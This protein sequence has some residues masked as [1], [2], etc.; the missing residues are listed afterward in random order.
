MAKRDY[1]E[2]LGVSKEASTDEIK[3]A[4]RRL[5]R[6]YHPDV[7]KETGAEDK[8]KEINEAYGILGDEKKRSQYDRFGSAGPG[9]FDPSGFGGQGFG[10][11]AG[12]GFDF[13]QFEGFDGF[14]DIFESFFGGQGQRRGQINRRGDDLR[15]DLSITL[16]DAAKGLEK[17]IVIA[18]Q[19]KCGT[20]DGSGAKPGTKIESCNQCKGTGQ[21]RHIQQTILGNIAQVAPCMACRGTG[22]T[23]KTPCS[24]CGGS[25]R[26]KDKST[27][28]IKIPAGIENGYKLRAS[29][30]G[31]AGLR[32]APSGDLFIVV[33]V[34]KHQLFERDGSDLYYKASISFPFAA[35]GGEI[36][37]PT[38]N[39]PTA[40]LKIPQGTQPNTTFRLKTKGLPVL[41]G[42]GHGDLYVLVDIKTPTNLTHE[43]IEILKRFGNKGK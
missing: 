41:G 34:E 7:N 17:E 1:Y 36:E 26:I 33:F 16:E 22:K 25:G 23:I 32:G 38:I 5:A 29:G 2:S 12:Q 6:Q 19:T 31:D 9:G 37:V 40:K 43:Q 27:L 28:K 10:G 11:Q 3:K 18:H 4:F 39:G 35:L 13:S 20:C 30:G 14:S 8:F 42:H 24:T 21:V 15:Y